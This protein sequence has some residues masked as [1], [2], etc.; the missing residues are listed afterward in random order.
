[1]QVAK[2]AE[3]LAADP[4]A[5]YKLRE[6]LLQWLKVDQVPDLGKDPKRYPGFDETVATDLR[7]SLDLFLENTVWTDKSDFRDLMLTDKVYL[8]GRLAKLYG[9]SLAADAPFQPV[10]IDPAER[11][12]VLTQ[13]YLL[14]S[15]AYADNSSPIHRG[16]LLA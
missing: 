11:A 12:G 14:A 5:W 8:N 1:D 16:V 13:P 7:T 15:F 6:F 9:V 4:R 3:R 2:Q 10:S